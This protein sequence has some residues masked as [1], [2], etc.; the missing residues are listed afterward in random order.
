MLFCGEFVYVQLYWEWTE[1]VLSCFEQHLRSGSLHQAVYTSL[2]SSGRNIHVLRAFYQSW[3]PKV[4]PFH[5]VS[6]KNVHIF[7][8]FA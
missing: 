5:A 3:C 4:N 2:Y 7:V 6:G 1:L 8:G